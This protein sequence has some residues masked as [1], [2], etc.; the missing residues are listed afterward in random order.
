M[1][2]DRFLHSGLRP[3]VEMTLMGILRII[4]CQVFMTGIYG[5]R[6]IAIFE[7]IMYQITTNL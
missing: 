1:I 4:V 3:A 6:K 5:I 7:W 2:Q